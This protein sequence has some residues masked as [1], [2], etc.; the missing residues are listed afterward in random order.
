MSMD[1]IRRTYGVPA[2]RGGRVQYT[3][4]TGPQLGTITGSRG[5][6]L[7]IRLD[8]DNYSLNFH[9]TWQLQYLPRGE[10]ERTA[11]TGADNVSPGSNVQAES[12]SPSV[13]LI[14]GEK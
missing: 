10:A 14:R 1:Y 4:R 3:G 9:P 2:K 8:G 11:C 7:R 5:A 12:A 13:L 6:R